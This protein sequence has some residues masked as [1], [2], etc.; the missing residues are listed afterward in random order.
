MMVPAHEA[1]A[2]TVDAR[3]IGPKTR[4]HGAHAAPMGDPDFRPSPPAFKTLGVGGT[5]C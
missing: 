2:G 1:D 5:A 4:D 3:A